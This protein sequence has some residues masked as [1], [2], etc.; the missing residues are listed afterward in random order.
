[1]IPVNLMPSHRIAARARRASVRAW[2]VGLSIYAG[3]IAGVGVLVNLPTNGASPRLQAEL[4]RLDQ[5]A[6]RSGDANTRLTAVVADQ[7]RRLDA[8]RAVGEHPD[9]S[10][11][12]EHLARARGGRTTLEQVEL[13]RESATI[14]PKPDPAPR[15]AK[16]GKPL[17]RTSHALLIAGHAATPGAVFEYARALESLG[18][19]DAVLVKDTRNASLGSMPTTRFEIRATITEPDQP[20]EVAK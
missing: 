1:M 3:A 6:Q 17:V 12:L 8:A 11:L 4:A 9:W 10:V 2:C 16:P 20:A 19:F 18:V 15:G 13:K 14:T 7:R 5:A